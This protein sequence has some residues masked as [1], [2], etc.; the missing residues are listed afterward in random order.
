M[1][2]K[3]RGREVLG[4]LLLAF[5][6]LTVSVRAAEALDVEGVP[7]VR[8][9]VIQG[10]RRIP[11]SAIRFHLRTKVGEPFDP[12]R[13][14]Q[15]VRALYAL[16]AFRA[17]RIE[18]AAVADGVRLIVR[19]E[20]RPLVRRVRYEGVTAMQEADLTRRLREAKIELHP[21]RPCDS[22]QVWRARHV[23]A[24]W[25]EERGFPWARVES[26]EREDAGS[27]SVDVVF[28]IVWGP[29][30]IIRD[31]VFRGNQAVASAE[32][33]NVL[34]WLRPRSLFRRFSQRGVYTRARAEED[35]Q[36][37]VAFYQERGYARVDVGEPVLVPIAERDRH[38][39]LRVEIP[40][41]E[42]PQYRIGE[43]RVETG[44]SPIPPAVRA[45]L[46]SLEPGEVY[47]ARKVHVVLERIRAVYAAA[48]RIPMRADALQD[49]DEA[50]ARVSLL[51]R[52]ELSPPLRVARIEFEGNRRIPDR[53]L[54]RE[55]LLREGELYDENLLDRSLVRLARSGLV[56]PVDR[57]DVELG[58]D[59]ERQE[60]SVTIRV[61]EVD[62]QGIWMI[63]GSSGVGGGYLGVMYRAVSVL[64]L[65]EMLG[66][67]AMAG[68]RMHSVLLDLL[69]RRVANTP[70]TLGLSLFSQFSR[71]DALSLGT[72]DT[73]LDRI[74]YRQGGIRLSGSYPIT[75]FSSAGLGVQI[76]RVRATRLLPGD[77]PSRFARQTLAFFW[78]RDT[79]DAAADPQH[80]AIWLA[81]VSVSGGDA[82]MVKSSLEY[83]RYA[84]DPFTDGRN[85]FAFRGVLAHA[86]GF[87]GWIVPSFERFFSDGQI[88]RGFSAGEFGPL[89]R[90]RV[91]V[92]PAEAPGQAGTLSGIAVIGG[93]TVAA[94]QAEYR[95]PLATRF[96][97]VPFFDAGVISVIHPIEGVSVLRATNA[98]VRTSTGIEWRFRLPLLEQ[99]LRMIWAFNPTR[100]DQWV[101]L[102]DGRLIRL[103]E[104]AWRV[105]SLL[106]GSL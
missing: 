44:E 94:W 78:N 72:L 33:R 16:G 31:V 20:E 88:V 17:V 15:D 82:A 76:E 54:R 25:A 57:K 80:G 83:R 53:L 103:R 105:R 51:F 97:M 55:I 52:V 68:P 93:D 79:T 29:R 40:I 23:I 32:L 95:V 74:W 75:E 59:R 19:V 35:R 66:L 104:R 21:G 70:V 9:L 41:R 64:G 65:G 14:E 38:V 61:R 99:P 3:K 42:G 89:A 50:T 12:R 96:T 77:P 37:L 30:G 69:V 60:V 27:A 106:G 71:F 26:Q 90:Y 24:R 56:H 100:L 5:V 39:H 67:E 98:L 2:Q 10:N 101:R 4:R 18:R 62:R 43:V 63:G 87:G 7:I 102:G 85:T 6:W 45:A 22:Q 86:A 11:D 48:G 46:Q 73:A 58:V 92:T 91:A 47:N 84:P 34:R 13:I 49:F 1:I 8:S 81:S 28:R 36:R